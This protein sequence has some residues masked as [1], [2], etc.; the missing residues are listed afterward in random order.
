MQEKNGIDLKQALKMLSEKDDIIKILA[1]ENEILRARL[2]LLLH[3]RYGK[4]SEKLPDEVL[5]VADEPEVTEAEAAEIQAAEQE[6]TV[7]GHTRQQPKRKPLPAS[8]ARETVIQDIPLEQ[9]ICNCC[10]GTLHCIGEEVSEKLDYVPAQIKVIQNIRKKY[11]CRGCEMGITIAPPPPDFLPKSLAS[12]GLLSHVILS[13]Y[14]DHLPLYRQEGIWQRLG[15]DIPRSTLCNW[16]LM[17]AER[18]AIL[19]PLLRN[20]IIQSQY[21]RADETPVQVLEENKVRLS[22]KAYMWVFTTGNVNRAVIVYQFAMSRQGGVATQFFAGFKGYL[23]TDGYGGY[24]EIAETI[25]ITHVS[26]WAHARRKFVAMVK[27]AKKQGAAHYAVAVIGKLYKFEK[28]MKKNNLDPEKIK[29]YRQEKSKPILDE[30][31]KWLQEKQLKAPPKSVLGNA[32]SYALNRW[33]SLT[34]YL[35]YGFLDIDNNFAERCIRPFTIGRKNWIFMGN[36][37]GGAAAAVFYSLIET[38]KANGLNTYAYFRYL[39]SALPLIDPQDESTLKALL[40]TSL[41]QQDLDQYLK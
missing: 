6:I 12:P 21:A 31:K 29:T 1:E 5:P 36:E 34:V 37:R 7:A 30:F 40:P 38:A 8:F 14:E 3:D 15:V 22:K 10:K 35:K 2:E 26:C 9:Q 20:E 18:L 25:G 33:A 28:E 32:I 27:T 41:K 24:N 23:Q 4:K 16:V 11:G 19:I 39:M 17:V 13:K